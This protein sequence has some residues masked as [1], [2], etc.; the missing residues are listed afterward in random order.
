ME[1]RTVVITGQRPEPRRYTPA[2]RA[3][4]NPDR[5]AMWAFVFGIFFVVIAL[6]TA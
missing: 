6:A 1:R 5:I 4:G 2:E 3:A